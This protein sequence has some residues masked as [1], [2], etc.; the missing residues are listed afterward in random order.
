MLK[1]FDVPEELILTVMSSCDIVTIL[2]LEQ[3]QDKTM[4][5]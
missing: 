1:L 3:V 2:R 5:S 4:S